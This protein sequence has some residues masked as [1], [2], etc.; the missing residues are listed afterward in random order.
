VERL[1]YNPRPPVNPELFHMKPVSRFVDYYFRSNLESRS[2]RVT[3]SVAMHVGRAKSLLDVG[4]GDGNNTLR[5][6]ERI[7]IERVVGVDVLVRERTHIEVRPYDGL[8]V[9]FGDREFEVV[10]LLDVLHHCTDPGQVL[11]EAVRVADR[12]VVV[13]DHFAFG[14]VSRTV[15][16]AM[17]VFGNR[18]FGVPSPGTYF[19]FPAWVRLV[20]D[21][22]GHIAAVEWP[23]ALHDMP[24]RLVGW[25]ELQFTAKIVPVR[26]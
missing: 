19:D 10:T 1:R 3:A 12:A 7:G 17:D 20:D 18:K 4:C 5:L 2:E 21:A 26:G 8:H 14:P 6:A 22:G 11:R 24:W 13:K 16:Y 25:P 15:L 23:L 9:P